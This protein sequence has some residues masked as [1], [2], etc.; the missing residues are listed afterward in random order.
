[1][2]DLKKELLASLEYLSAKEREHIGRA[3][4]IAQQWHDGQLRISGEPYIT[5][6]AHV[7][8][9][10][11]TLEAGKD[12]II[13][14]LLHD[15]LEDERT[16]FETIRETFGEEIA[17][18][19]DGVTKLS[20]V[21][22]EG[23]PSL[24]QVVSLRKLLLVSSEDIRVILIKL[25]DRLHNVQTIGSLR[26]DKQAR[27]AR[28]TLDIYVP[29]ARV[30]GLWDWKRIFED[31]CFPIAMPE[32]YTQWNAAIEKAREKLRKEREEF[33]AHINSVTSKRVHAHLASMTDYQL[34]QRLYGNIERLEETN[35]IDSVVL[36]IEGSTAA[37][38]CY[39]VLGSIHSRY[40]VHSLSFRDYISAPQPNGY[41]ALHTTIFLSRNHEL[42]LCIQTEEMYNFVAHRK[43]SAWTGQQNTDIRSALSSLNRAAFDR[44]RYVSDLKETVLDRMNVFTSAGEV[45]SLPRNA[46]GIDFAF[47][48]DPDLLSSLESIRVNGE[49][50][51]AIFELQDGDTVELVLLDGDPGRMRQR[52]LWLEKAKSIEARES[53]KQ[54][55]ASL[56][57]TEQKSEGTSI[58]EYE[59]RKW[60]LPLWWIFNVSATQQKMTAALGEE[61]FDRVL[62]K[63]GTGQL[64]V[65][66]VV[67]LYKASLG[68]PTFLQRVLQFLN[69][70]PRSRVLNKSASII[71]IDIITLDKP[72]MIYNV[73]RCFAE[74]NI[75][76][77]KFKAYA[78][79]PH[80]ALY[81]IRLE[82][83]SSKE[84]SELYDALLQVPNVKSIT[85][86][87]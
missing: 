28:E 33:V 50:R 31:I 20:K 27:I 29:F 15:V 84:Y 73:S 6:P 79:P 56:P 35:R 18:L 87:R 26:P 32:E 30:V 11:A 17:K 2:E 9:N 54:S 45:I 65:G 39:H 14:A 64:A 13:V 74:R 44:D 67:E 4:D 60:R 37:E 46:T 48:V 16:D 61:S 76:I 52:V 86:K 85:R 78:F 19:I 47:T 38:D 34:Y 55:L 53:L 71:D 21:I 12:M 3:F 81:Q 66:K 62:E 36:V 23:E 59:C 57:Q 5:H 10:L 58:L 70:L 1:M 8:I 42:R 24:R 51:E 7:A 75:N 41:R 82:V 40:P 69:L 72:G 43:I 25:A 22:Y 63:I 49:A 77:S 80:D 68:T 83:N